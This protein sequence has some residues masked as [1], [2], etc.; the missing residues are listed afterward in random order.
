MLG[1]I[2]EDS[3]SYGTV[4][5]R[6]GVR[7]GA[8]MFGSL[9]IGD[10]LLV[11]GGYADKPEWLG[12]GSGFLGRL[13]S[14]IPSDTETPS[15]VVQLDE[16]IT[17]QDARGDILVLA[18]RYVGV[19]GRRPRPCMWSCATSCPTLNPGHNAD[20]ANGSSPTPTTNG[21]RQLSK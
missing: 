5:P 21:C 15:A 19:G 4:S 7:R 20:K 13:I 2:R 18:L 1:G 11:A 9:Q 10:R 16:P 17:V 3:T 6:T 14:F 12:N 8:Q